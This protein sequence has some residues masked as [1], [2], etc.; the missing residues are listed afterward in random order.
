M[1]LAEW[2][3]ADASVVDDLAAVVAAGDAPERGAKRLAIDGGRERRELLVAG[4]AAPPRQDRKHRLAVKMR[5]ARPE[6]AGELIGQRVIGMLRAFRR[7]TDLVHVAR[8]IPGRALLGKAGKNISV[9]LR[10][11]EA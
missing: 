10:D 11:I 7:A 8:R 9:L 3:V 1:P 6:A 2:N 5:Q 4:C